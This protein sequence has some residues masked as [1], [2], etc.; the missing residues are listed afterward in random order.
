[1]EDRLKIGCDWNRIFLGAGMW[2]ADYFIFKMINQDALRE[3]NVIMTILA[4]IVFL[5]IFVGGYLILSG[6]NKNYKVDRNG[7][8]VHE[9]SARLFT[10]WEECAYIGI[11]KGYIVCIRE[12]GGYALKL[13]YSRK[14]WE[15]IHEFAPKDVPSSVKGEQNG[16]ILP[17]KRPFVLREV[18]G[19][20]VVDTTKEY[21]EKHKI[22]PVMT[23]IVQF[24][25]I[26]FIVVGS[27]LEGKPSILM[28]LCMVG[29]N[30]AA[31]MLDHEK[32]MTYVPDGALTHPP[33]QRFEMEWLKKYK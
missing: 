6:S 27:C 4:A 13:P 22:D 16:C 10:P 15:G 31:K 19:E 8:T 9:K 11:E 17:Q 18:E 26:F 2:L 24:I 28:I 21:K 1:M 3:G 32:Y 29:F 5:L 33:T 12:K 14:L 23:V 20:M 25:W 7:I 30:I